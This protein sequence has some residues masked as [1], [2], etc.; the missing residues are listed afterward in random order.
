M[1][2]KGRASSYRTRKQVSREWIS[3]LQQR[4]RQRWREGGW[5]GESAE[6]GGGHLPI[7]A[8]RV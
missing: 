5:G 8:G 3:C 7:L 6:V 1:I 2:R 4:F